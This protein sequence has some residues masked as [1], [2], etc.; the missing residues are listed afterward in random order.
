[1]N[2]KEGVTMFQLT[3]TDKQALYNDGAEYFTDKGARAYSREEYQEAVEYYRIAATLGEPQAIAN[4]GYCYLYGLAIERN[5]DLAIAYF[6]IADSVGNVDALY[7]L[8]SI[9]QSDKW[10]YKDNERAIFYFQNAVFEVLGSKEYDIK[11]N[12]FLLE[13]PSLCLTLGQAHMKDGIL[14]TNLKLAY[15][16]LEKA[17]EG[18]TEALANH[19]KMYEGAYHRTLELLNNP[20]F[21]E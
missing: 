7:K 20:E 16:F 17:K 14:Q 6:E 4:L 2:A 21:L 18:Y 11:N 8:G 19:M 10:G 12:E 9:F 3:Q 15:V 5:I 1:M 13:Y